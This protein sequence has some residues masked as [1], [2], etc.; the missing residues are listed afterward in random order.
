VPQVSFD[1]D[2]QVLVLDKEGLALLGATTANVEAMGVHASAKPEC[3]EFPS[4]EAEAALGLLPLREPRRPET[5]AVAAPAQEVLWQVKPQPRRLVLTGNQRLP[6]A[7]TEPAQLVSEP[8]P[9][10]PNV[11]AAEAPNRPEQLLDGDLSN[12]TATSVM[13]LPD[14][15]ITLTVDLG[16]EAAIDEVVWQQWWSTSSSKN[17]KYLLKQATISVSNDNFAADTRELGRVT[18]TGPHPN[19]GT[20]IEYGVEA[21]GARARWVRY[22]LEPQPGS[23]VYL[24][25]LLVYGQLPA[26]DPVVRPYTINQVSGAG[27]SGPAGQEWLVATGEGDLLALTSDGQPIW[28]KSFGCELN[29][30]TAADLDGD[31]QDEVI[32]ARQDHFVTV[33]NADG[34]ERWS[35]ELLYYRRPPYVNLVRTGDIDGDGKPEVIAGGENWRFYAYD[36][37]GTELWNYEAVHPSRSGAVA[38]L[39]GDGQAEVL[40]GT[41]YYYFTVLKPDG[42]K[43]WAAHLGPICYDV[44]V[45]NFD[46]DKTR[47][48][49]VGGG[50]GILYTFGSDGTPR[51]KYNTGD[52]VRQVECADLDGDGRDEVLAGSL[53][54]SLYCFGADGQRRWRQDLG[55]AMTRLCTIGRTA[56]AGTAS[57]AI[58]S[59]DGQGELVGRRELGAATRAMAPQGQTVLVATADG[60]LTCLKP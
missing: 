7:V 21:K 2:S 22:V 40:C 52:E 50:D 34:A 8:L 46:T 23:A 58:V 14:Q 32:V 39:D 57:G 60:Q 6:G 49:A 15:T 54:Y 33:L 19:F 1:T 12:N 30:V 45:G 27:L 43:Q 13:Y 47:G 53:N 17:T 20:P 10:G 38:D 3:V 35:R 5:A 56:L 18:D 37:D 42:T 48:V 44:A 26:G 29:D 31:G 28:T 11:F 25:E 4:G 55:E 9:G 51:L 36:G 59:F 41:H 16:R 24:S